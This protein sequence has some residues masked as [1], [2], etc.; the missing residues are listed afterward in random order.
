MGEQFKIDNGLRVDKLPIK[1]D[2]DWLMFHCCVFLS[3]AI[4]IDWIV[5]DFVS[6][7]IGRV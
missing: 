4:G 3:V 2:F 6:N 5:I 7:G 1:L